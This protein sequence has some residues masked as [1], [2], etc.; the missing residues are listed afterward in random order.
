LGRR[1][2]TIAVTMV[3]LMLMDQ[4][5]DGMRDEHRFSEKD[6][7]KNNGTNLPH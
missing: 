4:A 7:R 2:F 3:M 6:M 1:R 5:Q